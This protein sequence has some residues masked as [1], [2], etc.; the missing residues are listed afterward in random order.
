MKDGNV[1]CK[2]ASIRIC[3]SP[4]WIRL[5]RRSPKNI[6][7]VL[8]SDKNPRSNLTKEKQQKQI[9][10]NTMIIHD[11]YSSSSLHLLAVA[12]R[13][14]RAATEGEPS[15][16]LQ[17]SRG[18]S[19]WPLDEGWRLWRLSR[20]SRLERFWPTTALMCFDA[21]FLVTWIQ[22]WSLEISHFLGQKIGSLTLSAQ[23]IGSPDQC[24]WIQGS[25]NRHRFFGFQDVKSCG[26]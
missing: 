22:S 24:P 15:G 7:A 12:S 18:S 17:I 9:P 3:V 25:V 13:S 4:N 23:K 19:P 5:G 26:H 1:W 11:Q 6:H 21:G 20:L 2:H 8:R 10:K 16:S 14:R